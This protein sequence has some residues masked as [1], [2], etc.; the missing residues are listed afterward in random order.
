VLKDPLELLHQ[1]LLVPLALKAQLWMP[2]ILLLQN[3]L[4]DLYP[5]HQLLK[6]SHE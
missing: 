5:L 2:L 4:L 6:V 1:Q 3:L